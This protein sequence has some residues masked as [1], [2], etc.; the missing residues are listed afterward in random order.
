MPTCGAICLIFTRSSQMRTKF[1]QKAAA[2][3]MRILPPEAVLRVN[4]LINF[5]AMIEI[6]R[7][8]LLLA[9]PLPMGKRG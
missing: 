6:L 1:Q 7:R 9:R 8:K 3:E 4:Y 2:S 5:K